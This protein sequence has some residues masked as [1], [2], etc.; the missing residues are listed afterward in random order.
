[1]KF[2]VV[3]FLFILSSQAL[4][5][6]SERGVTLI[7]GVPHVLQKP[8]FCG[9]ACIEMYFKAAGQ[10]VTQD[11][12]FNASGLRPE[13]GRGCYAPEL[14][15]SIKALGMDPGI[16]WYAVNPAKYKSSLQALWDKVFFKLRTGVPTIVC[17]RYSNKPGSSEHFRLI[18][19][20]DRL[21]K[22]IL[23]HE[24]AVKESPYQRMSLDDFF[25]IWPL[26]YR[27]NQWT[28]IAFFLDQKVDPKIVRTEGFSDA[29]FAQ[30]I[31]KL[32][33]KLPKGFSF[34]IQKPFVVIG[35][36]HQNTVKKWATGVVSWT[37]DKI[38]KQYFSKDPEHILDVWLFKDKQSYEF[39]NRKLFGS[40]LGTPFGYYS[41][42]DKSLVM[43]IATGGGTLVHEI[44]HP[45]ME[46]NF[47]DC[48]SWFNEGLASLYEQSMD[49]KGRIVGLV[50][51]RLDGLKK[52]IAGKTLPSFEDLCSTSSYEFY[53]SSK[54]DNYAQ[55]RYLCYYLQQKG[56]L[57]EYY[58]N[59]TENAK[60]D[61][62]GYETL[63]KILKQTDMKAFQ[64]YWEKWVMTLK[65]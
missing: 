12:A 9:E 37:V 51:W 32:K 15:K 41:S 18:V 35:N 3:L 16:G 40:D 29:D 42:S 19:G 44:V 58:K 25:E 17:T 56:L 48:P 33:E 26:K 52:Q 59:F 1:M 63:K 57:E 54:G 46:A 36:S 8:D 60:T 65:R 24:P 14:Y 10:N 53:N 11:D 7:K 31:L 55:A 62:T 43:N 28:A 30:H 4:E 22:E 38:K 47:P 13:K 5:V 50:N 39:Y 21:K 27:S 23:Y 45:F 49:K 64:E 34:V 2:A 61:P 6:T 20:F